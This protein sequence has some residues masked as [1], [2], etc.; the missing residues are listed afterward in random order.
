M[1]ISNIAES[2]GARFVIPIDKRDNGWPPKA[3]YLG[4]CGTSCALSSD[5]RVDF[6]VN[7][8]ARHGAIEI[9]LAWKEL[10]DADDAS[11]F[12]THDIDVTPLEPDAK[13]KR[14]HV[15]LVGMHIAM[16]TKSSPEWIWSTQA[17]DAELRRSRLSRPFQRAA[18]R[19]VASTLTSTAATEAVA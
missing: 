5:N 2:R 4:L 16:R 9:K 17:L 7:E 6:P 15:G 18:A 11:R 19:H 3:E 12:Y 1:A 13:P 10:S 14:M 8:G